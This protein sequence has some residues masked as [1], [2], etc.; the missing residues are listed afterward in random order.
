M[1]FTNTP[2][3][4]T[5]RSVSIKIDGN[6]MYRYG[7]LQN[8]KDCQIINMFYD[9]ISQENKER[10]V[11]LQKRP[12]LNV[13][14][15]SLSKTV[16]TATIRGFFNDVDTNTFYWSTENK[17]FSVSPDL[18]PTVR[19]VTT[20]ATSTGS[21]GFCSYLKSDGTRYIIFTD[22]TELWV[23]DY[24]AASCTKVTDADLPS[25]HQP[26]PIY[27]NGYLF[28]IK[29]ETGD[30][31]NSVVD[32]PTSW[33][34]D[35]FISA[36]INSDYAVRLFKMK[37]YL[38]CFGN[39]SVEYF[40]DAANDTGSPL[41][42]NDSPTRNIG[43]LTGGAQT[44]ELIFFVGQD[45]KQNVGVYV[46]DG[47]KINKVSNS[48]V[49]RTLQT[50]DTEN[51]AKSN[52][53]LGTEGLIVST[54]GH[55]FYVVVGTQTTWAFD[56]EEKLWYEWQG[57]DNTGLKIEASWGMYNGGSYLAIKNQSFIS[58]FSPTN[59]R[60]FGNNFR[61]RYTTEVNSFGSLNWK[62]CHRVFLSS[63]QEQPTGTSNVSVSWSDRDWSD[64]GT[65]PRTINI[66]SISPF[67][68]KAG[69][70]RQRSFRLEYSDNYPWFIDEII[71][72]INIMRH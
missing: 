16:N 2:E 49:D 72:D 34:P 4:S 47:F 65:T 31:Y 56:V 37:N 29:T 62:V 66:F 18:G 59:Y 36:E 8:Q 46:V 17:V 32:D 61:C 21:V 44:G 24:V 7:N 3:T 38:I 9:R 15:Y 5:Y 51:N 48:I 70:F 22:G 27:L 14:A 40:W 64:G 42:R 69:R 60:D 53:S 1:A 11:R 13:S 26:Y 12:G 10:N 28:L 50:F 23:D 67:L 35:E 41:S 39:A 25:P 55:T 19:T 52:I 45:E 6:A 58:V 57:S 68:N 20:L 33:E 30:I 63:S 71:L 54:N 43:Y